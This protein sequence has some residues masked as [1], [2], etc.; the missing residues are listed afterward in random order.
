MSNAKIAKD[1]L[2]CDFFILILKNRIKEANLYVS[3]INECL[4]HALLIGQNSTDNP[5]ERFY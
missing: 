2:N 3:I 5:T 1:F 4:D